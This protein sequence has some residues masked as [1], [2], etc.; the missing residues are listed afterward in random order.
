[1]SSF[2]DT[3]QKEETSKNLQYDN[4][5]FLHFTISLTV[6]GIVLLLFFIIKD[7]FFNKKYKIFKHLP[8]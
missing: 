7:L 3:F 5:A 4:I 1:M 2:K 6:V 8:K